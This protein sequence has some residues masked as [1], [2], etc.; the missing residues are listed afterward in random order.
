MSLEATVH[1][2][3]QCRKARDEARVETK[4]EARVPIQRRCCER[5]ETLETSGGL[6]I[7]SRLPKG[8]RLEAREEE[9]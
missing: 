9:E 3:K 2:G 6:A 5:C 8:Q 4:R 1:H 7:F